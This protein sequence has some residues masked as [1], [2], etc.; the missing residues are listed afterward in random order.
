MKTLP[1]RVEEHIFNVLKTLGNGHV[2]NAPHIHSPRLP[3]TATKS[4]NEAG[5]TDVRNL[6]CLNLLCGMQFR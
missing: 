4:L 6:A 5:I 3:E 1:T 2:G